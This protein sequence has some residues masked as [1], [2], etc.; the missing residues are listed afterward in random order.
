MSRLHSFIHRVQAQL[1]CLDEAARVI[2]GIPGV[3]FELG[4]GNGRTYDHLREVTPIAGRMPSMRC[5]A[6]SARR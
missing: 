5:S 3:V 1:A 6:T 4:L 2:A